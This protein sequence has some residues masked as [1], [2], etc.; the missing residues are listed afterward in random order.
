MV[1]GKYHGGPL[2]NY[3]VAQEVYGF[4]SSYGLHENKVVFIC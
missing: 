1:D 3:P 2:G 4:Q